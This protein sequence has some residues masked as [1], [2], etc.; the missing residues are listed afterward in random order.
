MSPAGSIAQYTWLEV[1]RKFDC[2]RFN[3]YTR[4]RENR[5]L[6]CSAVQISITLSSSADTADLCTV[7]YNRLVVI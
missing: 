1:L 6:W 2:C 7:L 3:P 4:G 5:R